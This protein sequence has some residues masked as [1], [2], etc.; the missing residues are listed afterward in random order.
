MLQIVIVSYCTR[1]HRK[2]DDDDDVGVVIT[3]ERVSEALALCVSH[4][5]H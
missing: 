4:L 5:F 1:I 3:D 2:I